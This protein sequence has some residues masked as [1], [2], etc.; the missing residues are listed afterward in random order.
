M[1][2]CQQPLTG[3][4]IS[5]SKSHLR[6]EIPLHW[7]GLAEN[8][9]ALCQDLTER[10]SGAA[11]SEIRSGKL[12]MIQD[13]CGIHSKRQLFA[14]C[15]TDRFLDVSIQEPCSEGVDVA[16]SERPDFSRVRIYQYR[17]G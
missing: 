11:D 1:K 5:E 15:D 16:V 17:N 14:L 13:V 3:R 12:R 10:C 2:E 7:S 6:L 9:R 4:S 8:R